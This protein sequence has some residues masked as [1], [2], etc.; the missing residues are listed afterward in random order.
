MRLGDAGV[1]C[2]LKD[3]CEGSMVTS[4][5]DGLDGSDH[6]GHLLHHFVHGFCG[7]LPDDDDI[8]GICRHDK[9]HC[10]MNGCHMADVQFIVVVG[11]INRVKL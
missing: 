10:L 8:E 6:L 5:C 11:L 9:A 1:I 3:K 4:P 2:I 7:W